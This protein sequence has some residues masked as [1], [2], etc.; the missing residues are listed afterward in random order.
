LNE[1]AERSEETLSAEPD[2]QADV[3]Y[4]FLYRDAGR[5]SSYYAQLFSGR[6]ASLEET[7]ADTRRKSRDA[8]LDLA[9][10]SGDIGSAHETQRAT[11]R[12]IDPHDLITIDVLVQLLE[13]GQVSED[14]KSAPHG[15]LVIASGILVFIDK[16]II[17]VA[18]GA[19]EAAMATYTKAQK[20]E[21]GLTPQVAQAARKLI[22]K[23]DIPSAFLLTTKANLRIVGTIKELGME[24]LIS[25]YYFKHGSAGLSDVYAVGIK[26]IPSSSSTLL[27]ESL[28]A[29]GQTIAQSLTDL[30]FPKEAIR[31]T[32]LALFR[33]LTIR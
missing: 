27:T 4:D 6:L 14:V 24:E 30:I 33:K 19:I 9:I 3:L 8:G 1:K 20:Q 11:K 16:H 2:E 15:S 10:V 21:L 5:L 7:E 22:P 25:T 29:T 31:I 18:I 26:E 17:E 28:L 23:L 12:V 13:G 32:P